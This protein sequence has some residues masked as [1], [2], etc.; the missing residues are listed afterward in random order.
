[1]AIEMPCKPRT[2]KSEQRAGY[3][4]SCVACGAT[5][6]FLSR[7]SVAGLTG[8]EGLRVAA[9]KKMAQTCPRVAELLAAEAK[10]EADAAAEKERLEAEKAELEGQSFEVPKGGA[11]V[12]ESVDGGGFRVTQVMPNEGPDESESQENEA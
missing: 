12:I 5:G 10:A 6:F 7:Y 11:V 9:V 8:S 2:W 1:M 3:E 4:A